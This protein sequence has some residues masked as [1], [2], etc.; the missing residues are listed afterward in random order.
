[1]NENSNTNQ[2]PSTRVQP[3]T[4][5]N[6]NQGFPATPTSIRQYFPPYTLDNN[7]LPAF[8]NSNRFPDYDPNNFNRNTVNPPYTN[9]QRFSTTSTSASPRVNPTFPTTNRFLPNTQVFPNTQVNPNVNTNTMFPL[10]S[11]TNTQYPSTNTQLY[12]NQPNTV[13]PSTRSAGSL[14]TKM[15]TA[16]G[17]PYREDPN[18]G[19]WTFLDGNGFPFPVKVGSSIMVIVAYFIV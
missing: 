7:G 9:T 10:T 11:T 15:D 14:V 16:T 13:Y 4:S 19:V 6:N 2:F 8:I 5:V 17:L 12:P 3:T 18:T 1:M